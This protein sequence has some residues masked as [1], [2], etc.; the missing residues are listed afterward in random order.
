MGIQGHW[1]VMGRFGRPHGVKG[2]VTV[3]SF[4]EPRENILRYTDWHIFIKNKWEPIKLLSAEVHNKSIIAQMEGYLG[5]ELAAQ[6]TNIEIGVQGSQLQALGLDEY[7]WHQLIGM[8]VINS[9]G[10]SY[11]QVVE[12]MP[13]GSHD[14]LVIHG[15]KRHLIPYLLGKFILDINLA[16][17][18]ITVAW[19]P[20]F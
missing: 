18:I 19:D 10:F 2:F 1:I 15:D 6:L 9:Q 4:A 8:K 5:R 7:Y 13:T 16:Q 20:D 17:Q 14:I 11:G 3:H 12:I